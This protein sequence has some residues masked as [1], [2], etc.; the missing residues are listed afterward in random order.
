[1]ST[2]T[3]TRA[4]RSAA[5]ELAVLL[6]DVLIDDLARE[7]VTDVERYVAARGRTVR[8]AHPLVSRATEDLVRE[9]LAGLPAPAAHG[10]R[11]EDGTVLPGGIWR[12]LP[13]RLLALHPGRRNEG[14][15]RLR[16]TVAE[17]LELTALVL[18]RWGWAKT[19]R[20]WRTASGRR[21]ILG[22]QAV[23]YRLGYG[24]E[25][26]AAVAGAHIQA[27]LTGRGITTPFWTWNDQSH[28]SGDQVLA[29]VRDA[30]AAARG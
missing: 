21:C 26:T 14:V 13:D 11:P 1:M 28:V 5:D 10:A 30:A 6:D 3:H 9:A 24:T 12:V 4:S 18:Q 16:I 25:D 8:T 19:P 15:K 29:V 22:A 2:S 20:G 17:H 27:V 7:L 23:I